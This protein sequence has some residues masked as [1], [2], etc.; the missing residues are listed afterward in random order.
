MIKRKYF[1]RIE[2]KPLLKQKRIINGKSTVASTI[3]S[4]TSW[5]QDTD[6]AYR[7]AMSSVISKEEDFLEDEIMV[8]LMTKL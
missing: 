3:I 4:H 6:G 8:M 1:F 2:S 5:L 7:K